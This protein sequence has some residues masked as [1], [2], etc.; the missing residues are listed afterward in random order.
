MLGRHYF[1]S[2]PGIAVKK[3][4]NG[5]D[6]DE[7]PGPTILDSLLVTWTYIVTNTGNVTMTSVIVDDDDPSVSPSCRFIVLAPGQIMTF[8]AYGTA[9]AG[10]H[11]DLVTTSGLPPVGNAV[12]DDDPSHHFSFVAQPALS[13]EKRTNGER[14]DVAPGP[15]IPIGDTVE[16]SYELTNPGN[17]V[18]INIT[19]AD[20]DPQLGV[21]CP[22]TA[23]ILAIR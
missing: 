20:S 12:S 16:W 10:Q 22:Q 8:S 5:E 15:Y 18:I 19:A 17:V 9:V 21:D 4:T 6:A 3:F 7:P 13:I 11:A 14:T 2:D 23:Y 1:G